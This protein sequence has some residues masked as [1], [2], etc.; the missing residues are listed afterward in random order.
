MHCTAKVELFFQKVSQ[1]R[2]LRK[3]YLAKPRGATPARIRQAIRRFINGREDIKQLLLRELY[4]G[5]NTLK[6]IGE[7]EYMG[8]IS[9]RE[10]RRIIEIIDT[11]DLPHLYGDQRRGM[12]QESIERNFVFEGIEKE[13][14]EL[15][16]QSYG[17]IIEQVLENQERG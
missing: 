8:M 4:T 17:W 5:F 13:V 10:V 3:A 12:T 11:D 16:I 15:P 6:N 9:G 1:N 14:E 7:N 2:D